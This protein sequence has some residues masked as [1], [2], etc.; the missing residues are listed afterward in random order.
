MP[1]DRTRP[2]AFLWD[3]DGTLADSE[4][5]WHN[6]ERRLM[7]E[8]GSAITPE[9]NRQLVGSALV[10]SAAQLLAWAGREDLDAAEYAHILAD[11]ALADMLATGVGFRPGATELLAEVRAAGIA[12]ALVSASYTSILEA[13]TAQLP[14][15]SFDLVIGGD[16]VKN[17]KPHP[18]PYLAGARRLGLSPAQC[19]VVEDAPAGLAAAAAAGMRTIAVAATHPREELEMATT[20]AD[21]LRDIK[22]TAGRGG[23]LTVTVQP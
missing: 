15:H 20:I 13:I 16:Q 14:A 10:D 2:A 3:F 9:Q 11:H 6:A 18:E 1:A 5:N 7:A 8:L 22:V 19:V 12:C 23:G 4:P 17:G 21:Q